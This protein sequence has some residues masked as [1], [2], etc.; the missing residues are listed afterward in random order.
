MDHANLL[1]QIVQRSAT[2]LLVSMTSTSN[3]RIIAELEGK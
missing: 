1:E 3:Y 2:S